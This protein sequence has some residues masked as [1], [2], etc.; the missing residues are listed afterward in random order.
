VYRRE[1]P[2][3]YELR[4]LLPNPPP[5]GAYFRNLDKSLAEIPQKLRQFRDLERTLQ[6][7]DARAWNFLKSEVKPLLTAQDVQR[8]WQPLWDK[9]NQAKAYNHLKGAGYRN[10]EF[11]PPSTVRGQPTPDLRAELDT[12]KALCEVKTINISEI[13]S[14]RRHSGGVGRTSVRLEAGFF[15]KLRFDI[16]Q[17]KKQMA[18]YDPDPATKRLAYI[19]VKFDD[20]LHEYCDAYRLQIDEFMTSANPGPELEVIFDIDPAFYA[21]LG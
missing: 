9:L 3:V 8:G 14:Y 1:L 19:V 5:P 10:I 20:V 6:G 18:A 17:A 16:E 7:L 12:A 21:A 15:T 4:D 13:E 11:I 2:R